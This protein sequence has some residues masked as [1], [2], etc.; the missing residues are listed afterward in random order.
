VLRQAGKQLIRQ[1]KPKPDGAGEEMTWV[2]ESVIN[3]FRDVVSRR[4]PLLLLY[5]ADEVVYKDF[6]LARSGPLSS[7]LDQAGSAATVKTLDGP[8]RILSNVPIQEEVMREVV[9]WIEAR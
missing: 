4:I 5:G 8:V 9:D 1:R 6:E 2:S 3:G 7:V